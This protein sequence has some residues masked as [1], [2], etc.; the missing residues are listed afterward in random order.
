MKVCTSRDGWYMPCVVGHTNI[1]YDFILMYAS[2][3]GFA[4]VCVFVFRV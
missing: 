1:E 2:M 3:C 4:C